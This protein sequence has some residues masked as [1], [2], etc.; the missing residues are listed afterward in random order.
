MVKVTGKDVAIILSRVQVD[1]NSERSQ[2]D[3]RLYLR[4]L[5]RPKA[6]HSHSLEIQLQGGKPLS[7]N[8]TKFSVV[9]LNGGISKGVKLQSLMSQISI[10]ILILSVRSF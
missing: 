8:R 6:Q 3:K 7:Q 5:T 1:S 10:V 4:S 9:T 2:I